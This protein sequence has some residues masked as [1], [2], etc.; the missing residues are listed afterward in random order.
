MSAHSRN[1]GTESIGTGD[2]VELATMIGA[3]VRQKTAISE[4]DIALFEKLFK[5]SHKQAFGLACRMTGNSSEAEDLL[6]EA[7]VRAYRF[8]DRYDRSLPFASWLYR[9]MTNAYIDSVRKKN[10]L[11]MLSFSQ[12]THEAPAG[13]DFADPEA[14]PEYALMRNALDDTVQAGLLS[15]P[16]EFRLAVLLADVEGLAYE[17][18]SEIMQTSIGT[19]RSRI[20]RGRQRLR[21]YLVKKNP[22]KYAEMMS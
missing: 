18:I 1:T 5:E 22:N 4:R 19:V 15:L 14:S 9:I 7:Y 13:F 8:F 2:R 3:I 11:R 20:H 16:V 12:S 10:R 17:E 6:Q 21:E